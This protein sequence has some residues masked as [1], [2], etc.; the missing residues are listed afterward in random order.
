M[1]YMS[2][3]PHSSQSEVLSQEA[4]DAWRGLLRVT[5]ELGKEV[6]MVIQDSSGLSPQD[7]DVLVVLLETEGQTMRSSELAAAVNWD[8]SRLSH[9]A[10]RLEQRALVVREAYSADNRGVQ[11]RITEA[12]VAAIKRATGPHFRAVKNLFADALSPHQLDE[13]IE[14]T[15]IVSDHIRANGQVTKSR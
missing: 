11:F 1:M 4:Q 2:T 12:G 3:S 14:I 7:F 5:R 10:G 15:S 6:G 8:R 13:L 9:H